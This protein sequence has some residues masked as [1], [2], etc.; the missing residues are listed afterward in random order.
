MKKYNKEILH[1]IRRENNAILYNRKTN[2]IYKIPKSLAD[3]IIC[4]QDGKND[5]EL[6]DSLDKQ[7]YGKEESIP[8]SS[9]WY[10]KKELDMLVINVTNNCNL[11]CKYCYA[12][13]GKFNNLNFKTKNIDRNT[14]LSMF[15]YL[16]NKRIKKVNN[17]M[18]F[19]GEPLLAIEEIEFICQTFQECYPKG[20]RPHFSFVTNLTILNRKII[21]I[22]DRYNISLTISIDGPEYIHDSQ[23]V[24]EL[25]KGTFEIIKNNY[26]VIRNHVKSIEATY[27]INHINNK[28]SV[29]ELRNW[30]SKEF[31][32]NISNIDVVPVT[33][34]K[35]LEVDRMKYQ[36]ELHDSRANM[37]DSFI[38][39]AFD[40]TMQS[41]LFCNAGK[42]RICIT[43]E[44]DIYP[45]QMYVNYSKAKLG[46]VIDDSLYQKQL[47][48]IEDRYRNKEK[49]KCCWAQKF[50]KVCPAQA[51]NNEM[52]TE[53][54]CNKR[55]IRYEDLL[56]Q[57]V[58]P[59]K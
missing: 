15:Q 46:S 35:S 28:I 49:C 37:E 2:S 53:E 54:R 40:K 33:D 39:A 38:L 56:Y 7:F 59:M 34:Y 20:S 22:I 57:C 51:L 4:Y 13:Y 31:E 9:Y 1:I 47:G 21:N 6:E 17:V 32:L 19:G 3:R 18:F 44:G 16:Q 41:E 30:L 50:C 12:N 43:I 26:K 48:K 27:T 25:G 14:I 10:D 45:C 42:N 55:L 11:R 36:N 58:F 23:R 24:T 29:F 5:K 8:C 52:F